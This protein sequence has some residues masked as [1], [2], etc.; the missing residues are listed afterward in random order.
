VHIYK[1]AALLIAT[2]AWG[3]N[4]DGIHPL[5]GSAAYPAH[6]S[7]A[8]ASIGA[9]V[10]PPGEVKRIFGADLNK[11]G[12][13]VVVLAVYPEAGKQI[14]VSAG[15]FMLRSVTTSS[16]AHSMS[17]EDVAIGLRGVR[18]GP[19]PRMEP[20]APVTVTHDA[21]VGYE[22]GTMDP[23][24]GRRASGV[25][26]AADTQVEPNVDAPPPPRDVSMEWN[27]T[28]QQLADK[29]APEGKTTEPVAGYLYFP[30]PSKKRNEA[31][32]LTWYAPEGN[33][34]LTL[35]AAR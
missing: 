1:S 12:Y 3:A 10:L 9:G 28:R 11:A 25:Y 5:A 6:A 21:S 24:T 18:E 30:R 17:A 22:T 29:A 32:Q 27:I 4:S 35:P 7:G 19:P 26:T 2:A 31:L 8:G 23:T 33:V 34:V 13:V 20:A 15:D 14:D 16:V